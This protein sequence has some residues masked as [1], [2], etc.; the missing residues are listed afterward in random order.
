MAD[1]LVLGAVDVVDDVLGR[2]V[3]SVVELDPL[4]QLDGQGLVGLFPGLG[5]L[6]ARRERV[7]ALVVEEGAKHLTL[8]DPRPC[9]GEVRIELEVAGRGGDQRPARRRL[10]SARKGPPDAPCGDAAESGPEELTTGDC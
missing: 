9:L 1:R 10:G 4:S 5:E 3:A 6:R 8:D 7:L 2:K